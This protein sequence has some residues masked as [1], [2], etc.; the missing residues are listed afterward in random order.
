MKKSAAWLAAALLLLA[1]VSG[2]AESASMD[3]FEQIRGKTFEFSSGVG[4]WSTEL[5]VLEN[6]AFTGSFHDS[7]MGET[8]EGYPDGTIYGCSFHGQ[9]SDPEPVDGFSWKFR[10]L[11][12]PDE[13]QVPQAIEDGIR[14][15]TAAPYGLEKAQAVILFLPGTPVDRLPKGFIPWSH[16]QE[17]DPEAKTIPYYAIWNEQ[18]EAGFITNPYP[19][20]AGLPAYRYTGTDPIEGAIA[21]MLASGSRAGQYLTAPGS[22]TIPCPILHKTVRTDDTHAIVYGTFW[23]LN[24]AEKDGILET[25]SGGEYPAVI[26]LENTG[27]RWRV[28]SVEEAGDGEAYAADI[29]R[30]SAGDRELEDA[31]FAAS[32]LK[33]NQQIRTRFIRAYVE[34]NGLDITAYRDYGWDPVELKFE[35]VGR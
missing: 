35:E 17:I 28:T 19:E 34:A 33:A 14:Y 12:E 6:G 7:E 31:Y 21:D 29:R 18:D 4:A 23:I 9:L 24:Y 11:T 5:T 26:L 22:V 8:G 10:I 30:F 1:A 2:S 16:L 32:D 25:I 15:V 3:L 27:G 13:G 20:A